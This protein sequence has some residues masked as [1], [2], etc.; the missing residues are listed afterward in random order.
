LVCNFLKGRKFN[1]LQ[2]LAYAVL[3]FFWLHL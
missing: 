1:G 2:I 3:A